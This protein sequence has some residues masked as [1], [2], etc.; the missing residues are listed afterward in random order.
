MFK[1]GKSWVHSVSTIATPHNG[2][3][4]ADENSLRPL[5]N[6]IFLSAGSLTGTSSESIAY[7]FKL[8]QWG[9]KRKSGESF[10]QYADRV[11]NSRVWKNKDISLYDLT[12]HGA[13]ELN[14]W[15]KTQPDVYYF[16]YTGDATYKGLLSGHSYPMATMTPLFHAPSLFMGSYTRNSREPI[17]DKY[18]W[19]NDGLVNVVSSKY[20][21]GH[22]QEPAGNQA[23]K[24]EWNHFPVQ[25]GWDHFDYIG[26]N[27]A[28]TVGYTNIYSFYDQIANN[29]KQLPK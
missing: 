5:I 19:P 28:D 3:T 2:S 10:L 25:R 11:Y 20:P 15:V 21:F 14:D 8:D 6:Q 7:D 16:S 13:A 26:I 18:W 9:L 27:A 22:R 12:T 29:L 23:D 1:S 24:G 17:I 4:F